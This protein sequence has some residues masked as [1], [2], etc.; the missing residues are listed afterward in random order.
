LQEILKF[1]CSSFQCLNVDAD[2]S[3]ITLMNF[4]AK[5]TSSL[6]NMR[7]TPLLMDLF[8]DE[9]NLN[10]RLSS[11]NFCISSRGASSPLKNL[12]LIE[13]ALFVGTVVRNSRGE[14]MLRVGHGSEVDAAQ[15]GVSVLT[16]L[17]LRNSTTAAV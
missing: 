4:S 9:S 8:C 6:E 1:S 16:L 11:R 10:T 5:V 2:F 12:C 14:G 7:Y 17:L 3:D 13:I 15:A